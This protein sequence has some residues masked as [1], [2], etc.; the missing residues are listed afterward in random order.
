MKLCEDCIVN[1]YKVERNDGTPFPS[2]MLLGGLIGAIPALITGAVLLVPAGLLAGFSMDLIT[3]DKCGSNKNVHE[4]MIETDDEWGDRIYRPIVPPFKKGTP[5]KYDEMEARFTR[6]ENADD[7][8]E[9]N[10]LFDDFSPDYEVSFEA[11]A[12]LD[13]GSFDFDMGDFGEGGESG[14]FG[15][16]EIGGDSGGS[17]F[18]GGSGGCV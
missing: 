3:C 18:G 12:Q 7:S 17:D 4:V 6:I 9:I 16:G 15:S 1:D 14:G 8:P 13:V 10:M 5:Y 2:F 11:D